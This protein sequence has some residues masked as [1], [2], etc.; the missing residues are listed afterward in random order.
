MLRYVYSRQNAYN[1]RGYA[2]GI[3]VDETPEEL[4]DQI[5]FGRRDRITHTNVFFVDYIMTNRMGFSANLR[6]YWSH[7]SYKEFYQLNFE[8]GLDATSYNP[9]R[10]DGSTLNDNSFNALTLDAVFKWVFSPGSELSAVYKVGIFGFEDEV[11]D[12]FTGNLE[13]TFNLPNSNSFSIRLSYYI[14][15]LD[16]KNGGQ[17]VKN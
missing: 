5:I 17:R 2:G 9:F 14:D 13:D 8:G 10:E 7:A 16:I 15:W 3:L 1:Q 12:T 4:E 6:H 11:P